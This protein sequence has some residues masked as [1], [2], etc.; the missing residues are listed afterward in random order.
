MNRFEERL[1][2]NWR[3]TFKVDKVLFERKTEFFELV[4]FETPGFGRVLA[5]DGIIQVTEGDEFVYHEMLAHV[6]ILSHG[7][8]KDVLIVGGGDGGMLR[9]VL[10]HPV[11][12]AVMVE[13]D[14]GVIDMCREYMPKIS[15]GA[16]DDPRAEIVIADGVVYMAETDRRFDVIIVD[17]TDP[18]GPGEVLFTEAFYADCAR[19]LRPGGVVVTQNGVPFMQPEE[20]RATHRRMSPHFADAGFFVAAV[21]TYVGGFM[22]LG[23]GAKDAGLRVQAVETIRGRF[24]ARPFATR[25]YTPEIHVASFALP[26]FVRDMMA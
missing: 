9:E 22:T 17:S 19:C 13:I 14:Q 11:E 12:R 8:V 2:E 7:N 23:W 26:R 18:I 10:K 6:P 3:Q 1:Y 20:L 4:I 24:E 5:L 16:F 15:D 25:Y 21:P